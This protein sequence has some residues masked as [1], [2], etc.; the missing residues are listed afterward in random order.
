MNKG[1]IDT[2]HG[3]IRWRGRV[4]IV[5]AAI[6]WS[7]SGVFAKA[8]VFEDWP[9]A[10]RPFLL[11]FWRA[12]FSCGFLILFVRKVTWTW[13][14]LP[15]AF[16]FVCMSG[17]FMSALVFAEATLAIWLQFTA[18]AWVLLIG[19]WV[20]R[21]Y[22]SRIDILFLSLA[23]AGVVWIIAFQISGPDNLGLWLG[24]ASGL[25]FALVVLQLRSLRGL[26]AAWLIFVNQ[27]AVA[28]AMSPFVFLGQEVVLP[29]GQQWFYLFAFGALQMGIPYVLF[30][31]GVR[32]IK[33]HEAS[34]LLLLEPILVPI[35][36]FAVW[37]HAETYQ[38]PH[39]ST[40][41]GASLILCSLLVRYGYDLRRSLKW[42]L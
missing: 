28:V 34:G 23:L 35:W 38:A 22:A 9:I 30:A 25:F 36:V 33:S 32:S 41:I 11:A 2:E 39:W 16:A 29:S 20:F 19:A 18:P 31:Y 26:D 1:L 17:T 6:L 21:E 37:R 3:S 13:R 12:V 14:I 24:L 5:L 42:N 27:L 8:P 10:Q 40:W 15:M 7:T 4:L